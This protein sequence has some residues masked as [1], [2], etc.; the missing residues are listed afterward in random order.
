MDAMLRGI[1]LLNT[2]ILNKGTA[3]TGQER[4][5]L[6]LHGLLPP[7][8]ESLDEQ[9]VRAHQAFQ[10]KQ[11]PLERHIYLRALQDTNE[12]TDCFSTTL[13]K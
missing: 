9:V 8:I 11:D 10:R 2:Q 12:V 5:E 1:E 4:T 7:Q 13:R 3:F 6:G